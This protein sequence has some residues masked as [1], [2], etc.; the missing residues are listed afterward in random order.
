MKKELS[1]QASRVLTAEDAKQMKCLYADW[2]KKPVGSVETKEACLAGQNEWLKQS[3]IKAIA[4]N[5]DK[6]AKC[7]ATALE[8]GR[9]LLEAEMT[10][11]I[12][13][14]DPPKERKQ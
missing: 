7:K 3:C 9:Y 4:E 10:V 2:S 12:D 6:L 14:P 8:D 11:I 1:V 13:A 5:F